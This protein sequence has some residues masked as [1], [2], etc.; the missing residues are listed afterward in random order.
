MGVLTGL[1]YWLQAMV[2]MISPIPEAKSLKSSNPSSPMP[3]S[4]FKPLLHPREKETT[5]EVD[6]YFLKHWNFENEKA[7]K[8]FVAA[9]FSRVTC[10]YFPEALDDRIHFACRLLAVLFLIDGMSSERTAVVSSSADKIV[11]VLETMSF[12][13]GSAYNERLIPISR[14][15]V[16]PD[17]TIPVEYITYDLWESMRQHDKEMAND[18]LEPVFVFMRAQTDKTRIKPMG[19]GSYFEYR[20]A[21]VGKA[22]AETHPARADHYRLLSALM[23][24]SMGL[25]TTPDEIALARPVEMNCSKHISVINDV[26]SYEKEL[27][28]E[29]EGHA[30]GGAL[31]SSV[32]ILAKEA[33][34]D[35]A[36]SKRLLVYMCRE[37]ELCHEQ[38]VAKIRVQPNGRSENLRRYMKGLEYQ[39]GGNETWSQTT[40]RYSMAS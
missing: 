19:L 7:R 9:G 2:Y 21:D 3:A 13:E 12:D 5:A 24:F 33:D 14:G 35:I 37:W 36:A 34:V 29:K 4:I 27:L 26:Y 38:L 32:G 23:R 40:K 8:K 18:V 10:F 28:A 6:G 22:L 25:K 15:D 20:E 1:R 11:D 16:L 31:C 17:R 30:E 39:M